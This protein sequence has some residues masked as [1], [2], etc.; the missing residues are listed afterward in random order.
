MENNFDEALVMKCLENNVALDSKYK[1]SLYDFGVQSVFNVIH[2]FFLTQFGVYLVAFNM[3]WML[4]SPG[5]LQSLAFV[6][7][8]ESTVYLIVSSHCVIR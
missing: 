3:E 1:I 5:K 8:I 6:D 4:G 7:M 2:P